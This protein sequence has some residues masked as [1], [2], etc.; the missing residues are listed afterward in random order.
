[1]I[2]VVG[3]DSGNPANL[4]VGQI[5]SGHPWPHSSQERSIATLVQLFD[6]R[7]IQKQTRFH[8]FRRRR[9]LHQVQVHRLR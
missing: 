4:V 6:R 5:K 3:K 9:Q 8:D 7:S 1:V 2:A